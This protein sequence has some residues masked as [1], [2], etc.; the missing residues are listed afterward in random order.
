MLIVTDFKLCMVHCIH[1][2]AMM[3]SQLSI[4]MGWIITETFKLASISFFIICLSQTR[5]ADILQCLKKSRVCFMLLQCLKK[6][7]VCPCSF[8]AWRNH[9]AVP[10]PLVPESNHKSVPAPWVPK[11]SCVCTC[12]FYSAWRIMCLSLLF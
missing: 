1:H 9:V 7:Q 4:Y 6:S 12:S 10:T 5:P 8:S 3:Y 11:E 2:N